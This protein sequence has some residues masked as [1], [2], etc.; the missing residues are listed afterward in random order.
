MQGGEKYARAEGAYRAA[1]EW[2]AGANHVACNDHIGHVVGV[3]FSLE[4]TGSR[5]ISCAAHDA[6][7]E[8]WLACED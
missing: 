6:C 8:R 2:P 4:E 5:M 1:G 3:V 7:A